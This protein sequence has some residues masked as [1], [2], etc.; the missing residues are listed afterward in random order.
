[1]GRCWRVIYANGGTLETADISVRYLRAFALGHLDHI[2]LPRGPGV[3]M[4]ATKLR[5]PVPTTFEAFRPFP[6]GLVNSPEL[7]GGGGV[8]EVAETE[9]R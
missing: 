1:M 3:M 4:P 9:T 5:V 7:F 6:S 2:I 8:A